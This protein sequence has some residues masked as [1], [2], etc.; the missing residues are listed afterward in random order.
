LYFSKIISQLLS[1]DK[2]KSIKKS[3]EITT[4]K[5]TESLNDH[6]Q[7]KNFN[8]SKMNKKR[9][10]NSYLNNTSS[11]NDYQSINI[12]N[13]SFSS[14]ASSSQ[15]ILPF[16]A[17]ELFFKY[18]FDQFIIEFRYIEQSIVSDKLTLNHGMNES[19]NTGK[20]NTNLKD[21]EISQKELNL[22]SDITFSLNS[23]SLNESYNKNC[24]IK[25][26]NNLIH[27]MICSNYDQYCQYFYDKNKEKDSVDLVDTLNI[28]EIIFYS[29]QGI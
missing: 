15:S 29:L 13:I 2:K 27:E 9:N 7:N 21:S 26:Q 10:R 19:M 1:S 14:S 20:N 6:N 8:S 28:F 25:E 3:E 12:D 24:S 4:E 11:K 16:Y 17:I 5:K 23:L 22:E 18:F